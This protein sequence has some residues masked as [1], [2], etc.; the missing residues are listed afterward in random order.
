MTGLND[1]NCVLNDAPTVAALHSLL[2]KV[3]ALPSAFGTA[4]E[5]EVWKSY[6]AAL[7]PLPQAGGV[8]QP[9]ENTATFPPKPTAAPVTYAPSSAPSRRPTYAPTPDPTAVTTAPFA[10]SA[11][12]DAAWWGLA[13]RFAPPVLSGGAL[14]LVLY[15]VVR[16]CRGGNTPVGKG[17]YARAK[18]A[19]DDSL[20]D[21]GLSDADF[22]NVVRSTEL[23]AFV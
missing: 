16:R 14:G 21:E 10:A 8:L 9:Y 18:S 22:E 3:L 20:D 1:S 12:S 13:Y 11:P 5:R 15:L 4:A 19:E 7:P 6:L 17:G 23:R 2:E